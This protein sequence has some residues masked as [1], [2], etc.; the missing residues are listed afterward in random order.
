VSRFRYKLRSAL[1][2]FSD[3]EQAARRTFAVANERAAL[4]RAALSAVDDAIAATRRGFSAR[5]AAAMLYAEI[6]RCIGSLGRVRSVALERVALASGEVARARV[7]LEL[8]AQ[9]RESLERHRARAEAAHLERQEL[10]EAA[11][12]DEANARRMA[13]RVPRLEERR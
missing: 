3:F 10:R 7:Q 4:E 2:R 6:D 11:E 5:P 13:R 8:A 1:A 9:R 12:L